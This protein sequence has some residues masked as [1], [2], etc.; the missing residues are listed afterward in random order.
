MNTEDRMQELLNTTVYSPQE[1]EN[2][3]ERLRYLY[4]MYDCESEIPDNLSTKLER[5]AHINPVS[6]KSLELELE[7]RLSK[8]TDK[9]SDVGMVLMSYNEALEIVKNTKRFDYSGL[10]PLIEPSTGPKTYKEK[11]IWEELKNALLHPVALF[12]FVGGFIF[13]PYISITIN[14][15]LPNSRR[16]K[17]LMNADKRLGELNFRFF[18][19]QQLEKTFTEYGIR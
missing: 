18:K 14:S 17:W 3:A 8:E 12:T 2:L 19:E 11:Y 16:V 13:G 4:K 9:F 10:P 1:C 15:L 7:R 6:C 5:L